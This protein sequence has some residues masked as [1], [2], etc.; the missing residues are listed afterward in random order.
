MPTFNN[1][2]FVPRSTK[3]E[4]LAESKRWLDKAVSLETDGKSA[5]MVNLAFNK[6]HDYEKAALDY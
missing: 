4:N 3:E 5:A 2:T 1:K 6:A